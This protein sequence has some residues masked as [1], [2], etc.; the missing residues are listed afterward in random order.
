[1]TNEERDSGYEVVWEGGEGLSG[2]KDTKSTGFWTPPKRLYNKK[3][4]YWT[5]RKE[6]KIINPIEDENEIT[7]TDRETDQG[8]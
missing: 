1:M 5:K 4:E 8:S 3:S 2:I 7:S 6:R